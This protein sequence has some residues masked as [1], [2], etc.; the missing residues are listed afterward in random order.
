[1]NKMVMQQ[2]VFDKICRDFENG[3]HVSIPDE[4]KYN[5]KIEISNIGGINYVVFNDL[6]FLEFVFDRKCINVIFDHCNFIKCDFKADLVNIK[7]DRCKFIHS[8][9]KNI[10]LQHTKILDGTIEYCLFNSTFEDSAAIKGNSIYYST[11]IARYNKSYTEYSFSNMHIEHS[12]IY[13]E[14]CLRVDIASIY[15]RNTSMNISNPSIFKDIRLELSSVTFK[16]VEEKYST[17][18]KFLFQIIANNSII[19]AN[20]LL[21][22]NYV[23]SISYI[24]N[25]NNDIT[26]IPDKYINTT[27]K[28]KE[29]GSRKDYTYYD[30]KNNLVECGCWKCN[31]LGVKG[32]SLEDFEKRVLEVYPDEENKYHKE[33]MSAIAQFKKAREE[34]LEN[35]KEEKPNNETEKEANKE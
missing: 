19:R 32:G 17:I 22:D 12:F 1:M 29:I 30:V 15:A 13:L 7:F 25:A 5:R 31:N 3:K 11:F 34:Y 23:Y 4:Y 24:R 33:Y 8:V 18:K 26:N 10:T 14:E 2:E 16:C 9:F 27:L 21:T 28:T 6:E 20:E 35:N